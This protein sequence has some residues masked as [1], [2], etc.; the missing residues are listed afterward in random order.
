MP[1][2]A[3]NGGVH[4]PRHLAARTEP[5]MRFGIP[6]LC[7][8]L[9]R[10]FRHTSV[11]MRQP[12]ALTS[13]TLRDVRRRA[14][15]MLWL[16]R[17]KCSEVSRGHGS[18]VGRGQPF[19]ERGTLGRTCV[20]TAVV[21][22]RPF[23]DVG[24]RVK[25]PWQR[26]SQRRSWAVEDSPRCRKA[27]ARSRKELWVSGWSSPSLA[28]RPSHARRNTSTASLGRFWHCMTYPVSWSWSKWQ[29]CASPR[30]GFAVPST[31]YIIL[32]FTAS[33]SCLRLWGA[34]ST[35]PGAELRLPV[36]P[37]CPCKISFGGGG[38]M[39]S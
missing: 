8:A 7:R 31:P 33:V 22:R 38:P 19:A 29:G 10:L 12:V 26:L 5:G 20:S 1:F 2:K 4:R 6:P 39:G 9:R 36:L 35:A 21:A 30:C 16:R 24:C 13:E 34:P 23:P 27:S 37:I 3:H 18:G 11:A 32:N 14:A 28:R 17:K 25:K 15:P